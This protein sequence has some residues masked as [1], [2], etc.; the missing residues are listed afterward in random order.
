MTDHAALLFVPI[1]F[2]LT[3]TGPGLW[4]VRRT[5]WEPGEKATA[6]VAL[7]AILVSLA[8]FALGVLGLHPALR[9]ALLAGCAIMT[10]AG[11]APDLVALRRPG[12]LQAG[13]ALA[14]LT[15]WVV[16]FLSL[17]RTYS[18]TYIYADWVEH[19]QRS[20][21]FL[22]GM[23]TE[24][25]FFADL[26]PSRP[27]LLNAFAAQVMAVTRPRFPEFQ[28][29]MAL[30]GTLTFLPVLQLARLFHGGPSA[31]W[32]V[33]AFLMLSPVFVRN[34]TL[35]WTKLQAAFF[36]VSAVAFYVAG[37]RRNDPRR[38][39]LAFTCGAGAFLT[40]Y[41]TAPGILFLGLHYVLRVLPHRAKPAREL[42]AALLACYVVLAPWFAWSLATYGV[43]KVTTAV[44]G[45][46]GPAPSISER[47]AVALLNMRDTIIPELLRDVPR[48]A[49]RPPFSWGGIRKTTESL[50]Q[51]NLILGLGVFGACLLAAELV[52]SRASRR[53]PLPRGE[54]WFWIGLPAFTFVVG[55]AAYNSH[56]PG[57]IAFNAQRP[58]FLIGVAFLA[59]RFEDWP[60]WLRGVCLA[61]LLID[62]VLGVLVQAWMESYVPNQ[63]E[64]W[65][66]PLGLVPGDLLMGTAQWNWMLKRDL[67]TPFLADVLGLPTWIPAL[68][69]TLLLATAVALLVRLAARPNAVSLE[70]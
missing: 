69:V 61:G 55:I 53:S 50:Y 47:A 48:D 21:F 40:H 43:D 34:A 32:L 67:G 28:L 37:W 66:G 45:S 39:V 59:S 38:T 65:Q 16:T 35:P 46:T 51:R 41:A 25:R 57:G 27:P 62:F 26:L 54:R 10:L 56:E 20:R 18:E 19:Y 23:P 44:K 29:T 14:L 7:S 2:G 70:R 68:V 64:G 6:T 22:G 8:S 17:N 30:F 13:L 33:A 9:F 24:A 58:L 49:R 15:A 42:A 3:I 52:R 12:A 31:P 11:A 63:P 5:D 4:I 60:R 1:V 36:V